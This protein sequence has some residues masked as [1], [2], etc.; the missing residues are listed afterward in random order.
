MATTRTPRGL[1]P[2]RHTD[3]LDDASPVSTRIALKAPSRSLAA[4]EQRAAYEFVAF[5]ASSPLL[6]W[7][8]RGDGH[9][10]MVLPPFA[11]DD[12]NTAPLRWVLDGHGYAV[13][14]WR[15]GQNLSRTPRIVEGLPRWLIELH[16]RHG[17][18]VSLVGHSGGGNWA[19][20]LARQFPFAVRQ[21]ITLGSPFRLRPGDGTRAD[22]I[23]KL[24]LRD[25]VPPTPDAL[26]DEEQR[27]PIPVPVTSIYT[28]TDGVAPWQAGLESEGPM[29]ENIEVI[30][31]H[32]GL[33]YNPAAVVAVTD[34]LAQPEGQWQP[35]RPPHFTSHLFP[36]A[37]YWRSTSVRRT[38]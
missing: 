10:V 4:L 22:S 3:G 34:R 7:L 13:Y 28:R 35:F 23:A 37:A 11:V 21:V 17:A 1:A 31:S 14:G 18:K 27:A 29:R 6:Y 20:D 33:G 32:C 2:A 24:L 36:P 16:E 38:A 15:Q 19:R 25:Q 26:I 12:S 9:P 5:M 8:R 30:G